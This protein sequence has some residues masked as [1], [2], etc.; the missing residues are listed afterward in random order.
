MPAMFTATAWVLAIF[1]VAVYLASLYN[2]YVALKHNVTKAWANV[3]VLLK[4]RNEELQRL[5]AA[6]K[7]YMQYEQTLFEEIARARALETT[8]RA[9]GSPKRVGSSETELRR[10]TAKLLALVER[11]PELKAGEAFAHVAKRI[12]ALEQSIA[13]RRTFYNDTVQLNNVAVERFPGNLFA[14]GFGFS[15]ADGFHFVQPS[16]KAGRDV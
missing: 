7:P 6:C 13:D 16:E 12:A 1:I 4:Q 3:D 2:Q 14:K 10:S 5:I 15:P 8:A 9:A 11:Y